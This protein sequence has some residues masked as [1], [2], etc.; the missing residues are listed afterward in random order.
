LEKLLA[1]RGGVIDVENLA[2]LLNRPLPSDDEISKMCASLY[3][4]WI[5][6]DIDRLRMTKTGLREIPLEWHIPA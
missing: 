3:A 2:S 6:P 4:T 1:V 5:C